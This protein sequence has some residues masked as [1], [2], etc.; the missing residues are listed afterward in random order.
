M[1]KRW[2]CHVPPTRRQAATIDSAQRREVKQQ[3]ERL[4]RN[5]VVAVRDV[6]AGAAWRLDTKIIPAK[7][8]LCV[9]LQPWRG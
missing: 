1:I 6:V 3:G 7:V 9:Q 5:C 4:L 2:P 8:A